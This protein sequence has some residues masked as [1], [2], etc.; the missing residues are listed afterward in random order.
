MTTDQEIEDMIFDL[1]AMHLGED[2]RKA[3]HDWLTKACAA[4]RVVQKLA[5][6]REDQT[7]G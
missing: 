6:G 5:P 2:H 3:A 4:Y 1:V 7:V